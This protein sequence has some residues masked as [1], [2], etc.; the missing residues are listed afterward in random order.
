M[1]QE[2]PPGGER[3]KMQS[4]RFGSPLFVR[5]LFSFTP[6]LGAGGIRTGFSRFRT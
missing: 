4:V 6:S 5:L 1:R 3:S 2:R